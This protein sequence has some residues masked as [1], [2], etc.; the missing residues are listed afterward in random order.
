VL[1]QIHL[2]GPGSGGATGPVPFGLSVPGDG[3]MHFNAQDPNGVAT[4]IWDHPLPLD[5]WHKYVLHTKMGETLDTGYC[6]VWFDGVKQKLTNGQEKMPCSMAHANA[7]SYWKWGVYR[8]G[9][10]GP[11][12]QSVHYLY[13]PMM[14]TTYADVAEGDT[15]GGAG[16]T[17]GSDAGAPARDGAAD[18]SVAFDARGSTGGAGG[19]S[20]AGGSGGS[21]G[22]A[23]GSAGSGGAAGDGAGGD[24]AG[25]AA[26]P[27]S[28][29][30]PDGG[31]GCHLAPSGNPALWL[32]P[33]LLWV[34]L[35][36]RRR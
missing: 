10:G 22:G 29:P 26:P 33:L 36:R 15:G 1:S 32:A 17:G 31:C 16:G 9:A 11:I 23:G 35:R 24:G 3:M 4:S 27:S 19:A 28:P 18:S 20:G 5:S 7:G 25:G 14:G 2:D 30:R 12:G 13:K 34:A 21:A 6:E 8:S